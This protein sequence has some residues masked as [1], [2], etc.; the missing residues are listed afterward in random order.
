MIARSFDANRI[1]ALA[2]APDALPW[3]SNG[4]VLDWSAILGQADHNILV[5]DDETD[6]HALFQYRAPRFW[7]GHIICPPSVRG[8]LAVSAAVGLLAW[9]DDAIAEPLFAKCHVE[10]R[11]V[12]HFMPHI[13][14]RYVETRD[15][16]AYFR[17]W[18]LLCEMSK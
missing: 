6:A 2:A 18:N 3:V 14:F 15:G 16:Q 17:R 4:V 11:R 1:A 8:K 13:G 10:N 5:R 9:F 7:E 12:F